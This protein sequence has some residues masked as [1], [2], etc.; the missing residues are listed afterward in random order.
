MKTTVTIAAFAAAILLI[1]SIEAD[2]ARNERDHYC[3]QISA[4]N[5]DASKGIAPHDRRGW[6]HYDEAMSCSK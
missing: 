1:G 5:E 6:P 4:W 2:D 3:A